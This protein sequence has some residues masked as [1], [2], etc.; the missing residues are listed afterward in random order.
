MDQL[1]KIFEEM[2]ILKSL[3]QV[4]VLEILLASR[5]LRESHQRCTK[6]SEC[7]ARQYNTLYLGHTNSTN[8]P[9]SKN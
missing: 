6:M 5:V 1:K 3:I 2:K 8:V 7:T 9:L 4:L